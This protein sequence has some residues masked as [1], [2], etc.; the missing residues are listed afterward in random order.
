MYKLY[1]KRLID[2]FLAITAIL[3][4]F[5]FFV[6]VALLVKI[7]SKGPLF[8]KQERVGMK[9][10]LFKLYKF[11]T[12]TDVERDPN[13]KQTYADDPEITRV[14]GILRRLKIDE[15][16][17][18]INVLKGDM[19]VIGPRPAL[20]SMYDEYGEEAQK[21]LRVRPGLS[22][23]AQ[24]NGNIMIPW[25]KR[26]EYDNKYIDSLSFWNDILI[27]LKTFAIIIF[28]E[29]KFVKV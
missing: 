25:E 3:V 15:L 19:A 11:R 29:D 18:L 5:P 23:L 22:G 4:L 17:Q 21:R 14:G 6:I 24:V 13:V 12:M 26:I 16:P 20:P 1:F 2:F 28:G 27:F 8:Y 10:R 7:D 9:G